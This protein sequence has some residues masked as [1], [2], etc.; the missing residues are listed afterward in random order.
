MRTFKVVTDDAPTREMLLARGFTGDPQKDEGKRWYTIV[1]MRGDAKRYYCENLDE[2][3][4]IAD[5]LRRTCGP[6]MEV[7]EWRGGSSH[8]G[9]IWLLVLA[10]ALVFLVFA[11]GFGR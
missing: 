11:M 7:S 1:F 9:H 6:A 5:R 2:A 10:A 8:A 4:A 3:W